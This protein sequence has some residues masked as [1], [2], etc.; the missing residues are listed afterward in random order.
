MDAITHVLFGY[1]IGLVLFRD[2]RLAAATAAGALAPDLDVIVA[3]LALLEPFWYLQHRGATHSLIGAPLWALLMAGII[4]RIA[5]HWRRLSPL[6]WQRLTPYAAVAGGWSHLI[7]DA[8]THHGI[9][10]LWP[11]IETSQSVELYYWMI[12]WLAPFSFVVLLWRY[13]AK[14]SDAAVQR[15]FAG[16]LVVIVVVGGIRVAER[17]AG[18][19][20]YSTAN[21]YTWMVLERHDNGTWRADVVSDGD[22]EHVFWYP[23]ALPADAEPAHGAM[24]QSIPY[25]S[26]AMD[27]FGITVATAEPVPGG[28][29]INVTDVVQHVEAR[30]APDWLP[31]RALDE[32]G[33]FE[34]TVTGAGVDVHLPRW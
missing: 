5:R 22:V 4:D 34:A 17:P 7:L 32:Q 33:R 1:V 9:P 18:E 14:I 26:Y 25:R 29:R 24:R 8:P 21:P 10:W 2:V 11:F 3:P 19:H 31:R 28:W 13:R 12:P 30:L 16:I 20:V 15:A 6:R 23:N 27:G